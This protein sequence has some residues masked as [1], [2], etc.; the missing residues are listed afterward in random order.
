MTGQDAYL[1]ADFDMRI[2]KQ[3][4]IENIKMMVARMETL[5]FKRQTSV[6]AEAGNESDKG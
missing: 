1:I 3:T 2:T 6:P 4:G 5:G